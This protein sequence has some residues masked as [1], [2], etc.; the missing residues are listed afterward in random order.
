MEDY[1]Q[2][3]F[4]FTQMLITLDKR[5]C[6]KSGRKLKKKEYVYLVAIYPTANG[7]FQSL[8]AL[9]WESMDK[10]IKN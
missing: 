10:C 2:E 5:I 1:L 8:T 9:M 3:K 4:V 7:L 6:W